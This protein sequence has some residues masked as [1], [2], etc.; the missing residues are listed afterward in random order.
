[1]EAVE[2]YLELALAPDVEALTKLVFD[3]VE[4]EGPLVAYDRLVQPALEETGRRWELDQLTVADEHLVTALTEQVLS[5][6]GRRRTGGP[7]AV[8]SCTPANEHRIGATMVADALALAGWRPL[9]LGAKTP[10]DALEELCLERGAGL[11]ALS[12]GLNEELH[13]LWERLREVRATLGD[14]V[15]I[16]VGG[17]ALLRG[18]WQPPE[19]VTVATSACAALE[20]GRQLLSR[21]PVAR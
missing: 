9:L 14:R 18:T 2:R 12:V 20:F 17:G 21:D 8:V 1:M 3:A 10:F 15:P 11:V 19:G 13:A 4:E 5:S 16:L 7:L 6:V